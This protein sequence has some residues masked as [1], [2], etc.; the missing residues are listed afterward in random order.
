MHSTFLRWDFESTWGHV[1]F[2]STK[3]FVKTDDILESMLLK[4]SAVNIIMWAGFIHA[5]NPI[6]ELCKVL[7]IVT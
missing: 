6:K 2:A 4:I 5:T 7:V 1:I 3:F